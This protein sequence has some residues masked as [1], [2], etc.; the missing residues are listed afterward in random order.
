MNQTA[1]LVNIVP[2]AGASERP[3]AGLKMSWVRASDAAVHEAALARAVEQYPLSNEWLL[4]Y[5]ARNPPPQSWYENDE[6]E[7]L[8]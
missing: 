5:A 8:F 2:L 4:A 7:D 1:M 3:A 6:D